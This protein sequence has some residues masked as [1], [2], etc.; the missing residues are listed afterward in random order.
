[1][2][3]D[4]SMSP[5]YKTRKGWLQFRRTFFLVVLCNSSS[6]DRLAFGVGPVS[7]SRRVGAKSGWLVVMIVRLG[8]MPLV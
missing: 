5:A 2:E 7:Y 6:G 3:G 8:P 4:V 1:M